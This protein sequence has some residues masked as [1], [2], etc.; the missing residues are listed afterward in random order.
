MTTELS[1]LASIIV[2][3]PAL[4]L[5]VAGSP[6]PA[7]AEPDS[8]VQN[9]QRE[10][11]RHLAAGRHAGSGP[12]GSHS[13]LFEEFWT[14][15]TLTGNWG[16][17]RTDLH[18]HGIDLQFQ[19]SQYGQWVTSGG[20]DT[21]GEYGGV[22]DYR[23]N[24]D[25]K[26]LLGTWEGLSVNLHAVTRFGY[27]VNADAG[28]FAL[29][30]TALLYPLPGNFHGTK[31]TGLTIT[32]TLFDGR[33]DVLFG[34]LNAIDLV[35]GF[36]PQIAFGQ[37]GFWNVNAL[38]TALPWFR[39]VNLSMWGGG[40]WTVKDEQVQGG[41]LF[42]GTENVT[43]TWEFKDSFDD[44]VDL[45]G[46]WRFFWDLDDKPG[47]FLV[48]AGGSTKEYA[49]NDPSSFH[50]VPGGGLVS[51]DSKRPWDI[52]GYVYQVFWQAEND[53]NRKAT[54]FIGGTGGNDNPQFSN[55]NIFASVEAFGPLAFRP[56]DRMGVSGWYSGLANDFVDLTGDAG[57]RLRDTWGVEF[58]YNFEINPWLHLTP[59]LQF[60]NNERRGDSVA[61]IPGVRLVIDL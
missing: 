22:V 19:L 57:I 21:N 39:F 50:P 29:Q 48:F 61:I 45:F 33:V 28:S 11:G 10:R 31:I 52:A 18:D 40:F 35:T 37:E 27:D 54:V 51:T 32:Q 60:I 5:V 46:F 23:L 16:G 30:N 56:K 42:T 58:Y 49:S 4:T 8:Q 47:Y 14:R 25:G 44:G 43:D 53:P 2:F 55:W 24:V 38:V 15:D 20:V 7:L 9:E 1:R 6:R 17:L 12:D 13:G 34:K 41:F 26:K 36:F 59:D 3:L